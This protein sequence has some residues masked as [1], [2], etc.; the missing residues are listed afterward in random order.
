MKVPSKSCETVVSRVPTFSVDRSSAFVAV[1]AVPGP[2][3]PP[4]AVRFAGKIHGSV[5]LIPVGN[6][7]KIQVILCCLATTP[8]ASVLDT[9]LL[10]DEHLKNLPPGSSCFG[11]AG[12]SVSWERWD[13]GSSPTCAQ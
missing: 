7:K 13:A 9:K 11:A 10:R 6:S 5:T 3:D 12:W 1:S 8:A 2:R 4:R